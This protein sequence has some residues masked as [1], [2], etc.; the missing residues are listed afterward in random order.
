MDNLITLF[1]SILPISNQEQLLI[2]KHLKIDFF[3]KGDSYNDEGKIC[4]KL[5]FVEN[6]IFKVSSFKSDGEE[7]IKYFVDEGHF[8]IDL[9]SFFYKT[10]SKENITALTSCK[11]ITITSS[12]YKILEDNI[13]NF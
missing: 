3:S 8:A 10:P 2:K 6:G 4:Q 13:L 1:N 11:V 12:S 9:N 5:G 7:F